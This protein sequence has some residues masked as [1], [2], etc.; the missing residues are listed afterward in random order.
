MRERQR[1]T[2]NGESSRELSILILFALIEKEVEREGEKNL[3]IGNTKCKVQEF[4]M[5]VKNERERQETSRSSFS[6]VLT[7]SIPFLTLFT[8]GFVSHIF[9]PNLHNV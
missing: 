7:S 9:Y 8:F 4:G 6:S 1:V 5:R 2:R 3:E